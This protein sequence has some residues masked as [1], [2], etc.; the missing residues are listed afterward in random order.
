MIMNNCD[1]LNFRFVDRIEAKKTLHDFINGTSAAPVLWISGEQGIGITRL[2]KEVISKNETETI[3]AICSF[4]DDKDP[5]QL[6]ELITALKKNKSGLGISDFIRNNYSDVIDITKKISTQILKLAGLDIADFVA[7]FYDSSKLFVDQKKQQHSSLNV[8]NSYISH[9]IKDNTLIVVLEHFTCCNKNYADAFI[10]LIINFM[11]TQNIYFIITSTNEELESNCNF[12]TDFLSKIPIQK[13][14]IEPLEDLYIYEILEDKF[15]ISKEDRDIVCQLSK[16][17]NGSPSRLR[18]T[19]SNMFMKG[20]ISL[21]KDSDIA[22]TVFDKLKKDIASNDLSFKYDEFDLFSR[23]LLKLIIAFKEQASLS[24]LTKF[25]SKILE[26]EFGVK[27][28]EEEILKSAFKLIENGIIGR[29][30]KAYSGHKVK[31]ENS[32]LRNTIEESIKAEPSYIMF[33]YWMQKHI[34]ENMEDVIASGLS[35]EMAEYLVAF[36]S[37]IGVVPDW[38]EIAVNYGILQFEKNNIAA[39]V[40]FF[41]HV[42]EQVTSISSDKLIVM[43]NCYFQDGNYDVAEKLLRLIDERKDCQAWE[44]YYLYCKVENLLLKKSYALDLAKTAE[45][46]SADKVEKIRSLNMQQQILVDMSDAKENAVEIFNSIIKM[47]E[48]CG[49]QVEKAALPTLKCA[50]DFFHGKDAFVYLDLAEEQAIKY[51]DQFEEALILTNKGFEHFRQGK[52]DEAKKCFNKSKE[53]LTNLRIHEISYPLNNLANCYMSCDM[54][55]NAI[56][57]IIEANRWNTSTYVSISLKTLLMVCYAHTSETERS[58]KMADELIDF[59]NSYKITD[60]T[61]LRKIYLNIALVYNHLNKPKN[62]IN[63]YAMKAYQI[64]ANTS[65]WYRAYDLVRGLVPASDDPLSH[66]LPDEEWYWT[67]GKYEPWLVTFSHD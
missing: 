20:D 34:L 24:L 17:C 49:E 32:L 3:D 14:K 37:V 2:I 67:N 56:S 7:S 35:K 5:S 53:M 51:E 46:M 25:S 11:E 64:S 10:Q 31:I 12:V 16:L 19:F 27:V 21:S 13:M 57:I 52:P 58:I 55:E 59:I 48:N 47:N 61:M 36:H 39:A 45:K 22:Q 62:V 38:V 42:R 4:K 65:S 15:A 33:S 66:C 29:D 43:A 50:I 60:T 44:F 41:H 6:N 18:N 1:L 40:E 8:L 30:D 9:I 54:F 63:E 28:I 26:E 23:T